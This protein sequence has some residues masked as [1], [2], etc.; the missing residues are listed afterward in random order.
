MQPLLHFIFLLK[1]CCARKSD[2]SIDMVSLLYP[3][4][5]TS[6]KGS[7][8]MGAGGTDS[9]GQQPASTL[10]ISRSIWTR[11]SN[12]WS[13]FGWSSAE[14]GFGLSDPCGFLPTCNITWFHDRYY[15]SLKPPQQR[16]IL[17]N[18]AEFQVAKRER[19]SLLCKVLTPLT[20]LTR[21][22]GYLHLLF[23]TNDYSNIST[24]SELS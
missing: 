6:G 9:P 21:L 3:S 19:K 2:S 14:P 13:D 1:V 15:S 8:P 16:S 10:M 7:S 23:A 5:W 20:L 22:S 11:L 17:L 24:A 4:G 18:S 12:T